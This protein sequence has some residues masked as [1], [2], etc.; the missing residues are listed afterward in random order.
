MA[1]PNFEKEQHSFPAFAPNRPSQSR[2]RYSS[3]DGTINDM[4]QNPLRLTTSYA[5]GPDYLSADPNKMPRSPSAQR[6]QSQRLDDDL[7]ML[8][9]EQAANK[10]A[11]EAKEDNTH[12]GRA[13]SLAR[14]RS[15]VTRS[16][17][18]DDFDIGTT[19]IHEKNKIYTP[20]ANPAGNLAMVFKKIHHSSFLV[21]YFCYIAPLS[22]LLLIPLLFGL[23][24]FPKANVGGVR[25]FWFGIWLEIVWLT[26]WAG[27]VCLFICK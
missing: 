18:I 20:P 13:K 10:A 7:L 25:L 16:E 21:R 9:A 6:E 26:L 23:L 15:R 4:E 3:E 14:S 2:T 5:N 11:D 1:S 24:L 12:V 8:A 17:P 22:I 27:R 19:P